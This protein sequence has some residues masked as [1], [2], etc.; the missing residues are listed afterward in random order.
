LTVS[1]AR[2]EKLAAL[3]KLLDQILAR[4]EMWCGEIYTL[5]ETA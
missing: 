1:G 3:R 5:T 2:G 4:M